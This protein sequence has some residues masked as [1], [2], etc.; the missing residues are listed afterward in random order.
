MRKSGV[1]VFLNKGVGGGKLSSFGEVCV[2]VK[3]K[4][5]VLAWIAS[6]ESYFIFQG[7]AWQKCNEGK[8]IVHL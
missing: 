4:G 7:G 1:V 8:S 2:F 6:L 3:G 5:E